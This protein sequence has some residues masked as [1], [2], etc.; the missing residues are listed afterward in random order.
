[1]TTRQFSPPSGRGPGVQTLAGTGRSGP[2]AGTLVAIIVAVVLVAVCVGAGVAF[3]QQ[4][5]RNGNSLSAGVGA[6]PRTV[7]PA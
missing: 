2:S 7:A 6:V 5:D 4:A 1:M 3:L